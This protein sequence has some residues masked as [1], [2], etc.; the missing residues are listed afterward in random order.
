[1]SVT[2]SYTEDEPVLVEFSDSDFEKLVTNAVP[3]STKKSTKYAANVIGGEES[4]E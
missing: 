3:E 2:G 4:Y 1:M